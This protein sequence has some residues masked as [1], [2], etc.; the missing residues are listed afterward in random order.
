ME[1]DQCKAQFIFCKND[2][3]LL[4]DVLQ[5]SA[6]LVN[7]QGTIFGGLESLIC[8][9]LRELVYPCQYSDLLQRFYLPVPEL[10][11]ISSTV[12]NYI[13][14]NHMNLLAWTFIECFSFF[15]LKALKFIKNKLW[16]S[17]F[18]SVQTRNPFLCENSS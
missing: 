7:S 15:L 12:V 8:I 6:D 16:L 3:L 11:M 14:E 1:P 2:I 10:S 4:V 13:Y 17:F 5:I 18:S 9:L